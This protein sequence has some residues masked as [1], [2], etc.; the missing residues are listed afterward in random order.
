MK[1]AGK[2]IG[3]NVQI[4]GY[5]IP[6]Q[7]GGTDIG[8]NKG[9]DLFHKMICVYDWGRD[10]KGCGCGSCLAPAFYGIFEFAFQGSLIHRF[11]NIAEAMHH[12]GLL[13][14]VKALM[15]SQDQT[16]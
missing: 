3:I 13:G 10:G 7:V 2:I 14:I 12:N 9:S 1:E 5:H 4:S 6:V 8:G 11:Q 16:L 15:A